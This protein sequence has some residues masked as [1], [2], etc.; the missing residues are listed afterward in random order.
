MDPFA[1]LR[2]RG[3]G[4][5]RRSGFCVPFLPLPHPLEAKDPGGSGHHGPRATKVCTG[6]RTAPQRLPGGKEPRRWLLLVASPGGGG[7]GVSQQRRPG[8][9]PGVSWEPPP[10]AQSHL[11]Q[12]A[13][14]PPGWCWEVPWGGGG[15]R[16]PTPPA[17][18]L[19]CCS[20]EG[21]RR[22]ARPAAWATES[23]GHPVP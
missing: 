17:Q 3:E 20:S 13:A 19:G 14:G 11:R 8:M 4:T 12:A 9:S 6:F 7:A 1:L 23:P 15:R 18:P 5:G 2:G 21:T 10:G 16:R 22:S